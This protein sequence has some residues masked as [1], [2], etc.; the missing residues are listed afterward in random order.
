MAL[1][2]GG[3]GKSGFGGHAG[4]GSQ[5]VVQAQLVRDQDLANDGT[6]LCIGQGEFNSRCGHVM[7]LIVLQMQAKDK[8]AVLLLV[9]AAGDDADRLDQLGPQLWQVYA[10]WVSMPTP[11]L[12]V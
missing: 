5:G 1:Q 8:V 6:L 9:K 10:D 7:G 11:M 3:E 4:A 12:S 2:L